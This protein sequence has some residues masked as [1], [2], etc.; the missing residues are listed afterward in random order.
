MPD[1]LDYECGSGKIKFVDDAK[2]ANA[3]TPGVPGSG[4]FFVRWDAGFF[5]QL[6]NGFKDVQDNWCREFTQIFFN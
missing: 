4:K 1:I 3:M 6:F 5:S 2:I